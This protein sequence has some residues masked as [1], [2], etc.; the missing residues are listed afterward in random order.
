MAKVTGYDGLCSRRRICLSDWRKNTA[1]K[2]TM[3]R[4]TENHI[5]LPAIFVCVYPEVQ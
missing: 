4:M 1:A 3:T 2:T 5:K